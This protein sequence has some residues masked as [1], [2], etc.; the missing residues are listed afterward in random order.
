VQSE[1]GADATT[2]TLGQQFGVVVGHG[3]VPLAR[4]MINSHG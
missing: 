2:A 1:T 4:V 3:E